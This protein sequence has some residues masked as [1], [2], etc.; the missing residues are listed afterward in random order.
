MCQEVSSPH[1]SSAISSA[2]HSELEARCLSFMY[3]GLAASTHCTYACAQE[4]FVNF[5]IMIGHLSP[6]GS[7]CPATEWTLCLFATYLAD[8]LR[9]SSIKVHLSAVLSLHV[10]QGFPDPL[11]NCL[12]L[13][14]VVRGI[15]RSQGT[16]PSKPCLPI[17]SNILRLIHSALDLNSFDDVMF[18]D[19][20]LLAY[21]GFLRSAE[22]TVP[23]L[24]AFNP[25]LHLS[26]S[27]IVVD[28]PLNPS[29]LQVCIKASKT[30][31][32]WKG[33]NIVIGLGFPPLCAV[34]AVVCYLA[35]HGNRPGPLFLFENGL[36]LT[37]SLLTDRLR[38]I[39]LSAGLPGD[40]SSHSFR[41]GV[42]TSAARAGLPDHLIQV[43][44]R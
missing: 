5:C 38:A 20:C 13:Q 39:L 1:P 26:L 41:I 37:R 10:D 9:Y 8:S 32:F 27:D 40:F 25:C 28:V 15:K 11:E 18:W 22:F 2:L 12:R 14:R 19:A 29:C 30:D 23:S 44:G 17:S 43:L 24:S 33:C 35:H 4:K 42:A 6:F 34:Q 7:P 31:P 36:P 3:Q 21:F 16:L